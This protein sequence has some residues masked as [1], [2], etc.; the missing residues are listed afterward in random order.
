MVTG[1]P[2]EGRNRA[3]HRWRGAGPRVVVLVVVGVSLT[4]CG[5]SPSKGVAGLGSTTTTGRGSAAQAPV[6]SALRFA[7]CMRSNGVTNWPD[8]S[9]NGQAQ[10][11]NH[12]DASSPAFQS[13]Y[14]DCRKYAPGGEVGPPT[15]TAAQLRV[16]LTFAQCMHKHGYPQFPEPLATAPGPDQTEFTLGQGMYFPTHGTIGV[17]S[18]AFTRAAK[19]CGVQP[20]AGP[21]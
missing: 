21:P 20:F 8:P 13:A 5:A 7:S 3:A 15:P 14:N 6:A 12:I 1:H 9:S 4:A 18:A 17:G 2:N 19:A 11:I 10:S 16:A